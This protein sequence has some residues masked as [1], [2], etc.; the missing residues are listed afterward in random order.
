MGEQS[1]SR[2]IA[3]HGSHSSKTDECIRILAEEG[4]ARGWQVLSFDLPRHGERAGGAEPCTA[5]VCVR[6]LRE[7]LRFARQGTRRTALFGCSMGAC[8][9]LLAYGRAGLERALLLSPVIDMAPLIRGM[10]AGCGMDEEDLHR[11]G[12]I[13][14]PEETLYWDDYL[15]LLAHPV[16]AWEA[17]THILR[18]EEDALCSRGE[19]ACFAQ[20]FGCELTERPGSG[21][22]FHT[23]EELAYFRRWLGERL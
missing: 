11:R 14:T 21:H 2:I 23:G 18:G 7:V 1:Q 13:Q 10:L 19:A 12:V 6:E 4:A 22:W 5:A 9:S 20:R 8:F 3:V 16:R 17:P 15:Y